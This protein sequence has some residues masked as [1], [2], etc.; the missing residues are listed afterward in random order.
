QNILDGLLSIILNEMRAAWASVA[1]MEFSIETH[2]TEPQLS[3]SAA[4]NEPVVAISIEVQIGESA[5]G[6]MNLAIPSVILK[7]L[8][9]KFDH[10]GSSRKAQATEE[11]QARM[12]RLARQATSRLD[13]RLQGPTL[14]VETLLELKDGDV[15]AFDYPV[16]RTG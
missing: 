12:L 11:E 14:G 5:S 6:M 2:E 7:M 8:R 13:A 15:I 16:T 4:P 10:Q 1:A 9:Q 3:Q